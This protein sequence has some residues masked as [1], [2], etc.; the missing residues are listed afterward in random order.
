MVTGRMMAVG[1]VVVVVSGSEVG[2]RVGG[3]DERGN[4]KDDKDNFR[5]RSSNGR[6][7]VRK[8]GGVLMKVVCKW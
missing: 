3:C 8:R 5:A 6:N 1:V 4:Y 2:K 7:Q